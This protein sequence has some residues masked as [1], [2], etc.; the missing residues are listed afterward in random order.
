MTSPEHHAGAGCSSK[1]GGPTALRSLHDVA[2][3]IGVLDAEGPIAHA[4]ANR[5]HDIFGGPTLVLL[6]QADEDRWSVV[7]SRG[8]EP[9]ASLPCL[10]GCHLDLHCLVREGR[11]LGLSDVAPGADSSTTAAYA[12][13]SFGPLEA[14]GRTLGLLGVRAG[15]SLGEEQLELLCAVASIAA[16]ALEQARLRRLAVE[17]ARRRVCLSRYFS[18]QVTDLL[19]AADTESLRRGLRCEAT[20]LFSDVRG[21]T[22]FSE[23]LDAAIV[24]ELL[25]HYFRETTSLVFQHGG[26]VDKLIGDGMLAVFGAPRPLPDH[27]GAAVRCAMAIQSV[28]KR[29]DFRRYGLE[30]FEVGVGLHSGPVLLGDVGGGAFLNFTVMGNTV[31]VASRVQGLTKEL[32]TPVLLT[33][34]VV[35]ATTGEVGQVERVGPATVRGVAAPVELYRF[36]ES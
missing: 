5:A 25:D 10:S 15:T 24:V 9:A 13:Y 30:R 27:A 6:R 26:M 21:F 3:E 12:G 7:A 11:A 20:V 28:V 32:A 19:L 14:G 4:T 36:K 31:N 17:E 18:P 33:E 8:L 22:A 16:T 23:R 1:G 29:L 34:A 2:K 35:R